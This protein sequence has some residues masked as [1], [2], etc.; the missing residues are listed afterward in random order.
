ME[1]TGHERHRWAR[2]VGEAE[3]GLSNRQVEMRGGA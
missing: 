3:A 1:P 2:N